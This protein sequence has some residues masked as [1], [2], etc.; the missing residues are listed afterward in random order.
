MSN[1]KT[2]KILTEILCYVSFN[3][4]FAERANYIT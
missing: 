4:S 3:L 1:E 2:E